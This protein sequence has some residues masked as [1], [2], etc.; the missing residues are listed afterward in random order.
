MEKKSININV[1]QSSSKGNCIILDDNNTYLVLDFGVENSIWNNALKHLNISNKKIAGILLTHYHI[2]HIRTIEKNNKNL[3]FYSSKATFD[4]IDNKYK[5]EYNK[6]ILNNSINKWIKINNSNW[7]IKPFYTCHNAI[8]SLCFLIKNKNKQLVY[9]T[10]TKYFFNKKFKNKDA[11][12][13]ESPFEVEYDVNNKIKNI[14]NSSSELNHLKLSETEKLL[15]LYKAKKTK[16]FIFSHLNPCI[17]D[18]SVI[19]SLSNKYTNKKLIV[20]YIK[21][22]EIIKYRFH[23]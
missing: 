11:Y 3:N 20:S 21:P 16:L 4:Y 5:I 1:V 23:I 6:N 19:D 13:I 22:N 14:V 10:D 9:I 2:D 15:N 17:K 12:I 7:K 8:E 18:F